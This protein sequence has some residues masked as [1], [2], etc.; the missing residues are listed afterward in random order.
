MVKIEGRP[1]GRRQLIQSVEPAAASFVPNYGPEL[2]APLGLISLVN[3]V[4]FVVW[5][6]FV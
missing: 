4:W 6:Y 5:V 1:L 3:V 2:S